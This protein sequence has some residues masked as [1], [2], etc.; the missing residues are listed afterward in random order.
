MSHIEKHSLWSLLNDKEIDS[1]TIPKIQRDYA[2]GRTD[3]TTKEI[4][5]QLLAAMKNAINKTD[6]PLDLNLV[7]GSVNDRKFEPIDGQQR[8][9]TLWLLHWYVAQKENRW[10]DAVQATLAKFNYS[11]RKRSEAFCQW[12]LQTKKMEF[13]NADKPSKIIKETAG[14]SKNWEHDPTVQGML[15]MLDAIHEKFKETADLWG[16]LKDTNN[17]HLFFNFMSLENFGL[18]DDLYFKMNA[19]G[20]ALTDLAKVK[21]Q[22]LEVL[23][24]QTAIGKEETEKFA[25]KMDGEWLKFFWQKMKESKGNRAEN[26][27]ASFL[28]VIEFVIDRQ[29]EQY[30]IALT[31]KKEEHPRPL[32]DKVEELWAKDEKTFIFLV[33]VMDNLNSITEASSAIFYKENLDA[34]K[35]DD[36]RVALLIDVQNDRK[37]R[38]VDLMVHLINHNVNISLK[39]LM[40]FSLMK[41]VVELQ[42]K[43]INPV[44]SFA[45]FKESDKQELSDFLRVV[46]NLHLWAND[47]PLIETLQNKTDVYKTLSEL[48]ESNNPL[49]E[50]EIT[51]A[52]L[53][54]EDPAWRPVIF[55]LEDHPLLR[56]A[57]HNFMFDDLATL[58]KQKDSFFTI[59]WLD[60]K[61][62]SNIIRWWLSVDHK[63]HVGGVRFFGGYDKWSEILTHYTSKESLE[64]FL[65]IAHKVNVS[66]PTADDMSEDRRE[67]KDWDYYFITYGEMTETWGRDGLYYWTN[68]WQIDR[69]NKSTRGSSHYNP[70]HFTVVNRIPSEVLTEDTYKILRKNLWHSDRSQGSVTL[71]NS[72]ALWLTDKG[73]WQVDGHPR[74]TRLDP[75]HNLDLIETAVE[76]IKDYLKEQGGKS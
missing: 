16:K 60:Q 1:I 58:T 39:R 5:D 51:K 76:F 36:D 28:R 24:E 38:T 27:D 53:I 29:C 56:G 14:F 33:D 52:K 17:P 31:I 69:L 3:E 26:T 71:P 40:L 62:T 67:K 55:A 65:K 63:Y 22:L 6:E 46:R 48:T 73:Y 37:D 23:E 30:G 2:Q 72:V 20:K 34:D 50:N 54:I 74:T 21:N 9:T 42:K 12:L 64:K 68:Q 61:M 7:Y 44:K 70:Y 13:A 10:D 4:R 18:T 25:K 43:Q 41:R 47:T 75:S 45:E 49:L 57:L 8:L 35:G 32:K 66:A 19:R 59:T 11:A 15:V